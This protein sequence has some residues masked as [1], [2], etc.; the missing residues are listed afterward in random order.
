V[1]RRVIGLAILGF[2][3]LGLGALAHRLLHRTAVERLAD[4]ATRVAP[5][6]YYYTVLQNDSIVG[7]AS[8]AIDTTNG[9]FRST[10][11][12]QGRLMVYGDS[13]RV[14]ASATAYL[15]PQFV[16]DSFAL[17]VRGD[18]SPWHMRGAPPR[19]GPAV[20]LPTTAPVVFMLSGSPHVG[21]EDSVWIYNPVA[22]AT[23]RGTLR[24]MAESLF[25]IVD[26]AAYDSAH[27]EWTPA[28]ADT[29]RAWSIAPPTSGL[30]VWVD[31]QGRIVSASEAGG[32]K[33]VRTA[34]EL[35]FE[36]WHT[37]RRRRRLQ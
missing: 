36:N 23:Q 24:I 30:V 37:L 10:D 27:T 8:S 31:A 35:A 7:V 32:L 6:T 5:A 28:H 25:T 33:L 11:L 34:Y 4:V 9:R 13:Q 2:W 16:L 22:G 20:L 14:E 21:R 18:Q 29:I 12:F 3:V 26:S 17:A 19:P 1:N 15:S